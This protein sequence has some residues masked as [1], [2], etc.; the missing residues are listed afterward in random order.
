MVARD[1]K[2]GASGRLE[3]RAESVARRRAGRGRNDPPATIP[4]AGIAAV[5]T[6]AGRF[7]GR[8]SLNQAADRARVP[9]VFA[10]K[11]GLF[12]LCDRSCR[13]LRAPGS[14]LL[15]LAAGSATHGPRPDVV[16]R[17]GGVD[18]TGSTRPPA[19]RWS[20][21]AAGCS[22][23]PRS[24]K[25][26]L[27]L[28]LGS[29]PAPVQDVQRARRRA[30]LVLSYA[31]PVRHYHQSRRERSRAQVVACWLG[32]QYKEVLERHIRKRRVLAPDQSAIRA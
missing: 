22:V 18:R 31:W 7:R 1:A 8:G 25:P 13:R 24:D 15:R 5:V 6:S 17:E 26:A 16:C 12:S 11:K 10:H 27:L 30:F 4:M 19:G 14:L 28:P 23:G 29:P 20:A 3:S 32:L 2:S 21:T 9:T